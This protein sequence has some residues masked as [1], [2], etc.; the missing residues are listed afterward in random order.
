MKLTLLTLL[1]T[2]AFAQCTG[3]PP[4]WPS[5]A[6]GVTCMWNGYSE[7]Q[8]P[9]TP[10]CQNMRMGTNITEYDASYYDPSE[11]QYD[12]CVSTLYVCDSN[13][14]VFL[15]AAEKHRATK[16]WMPDFTKLFSFMLPKFPHYGWAAIGRYGKCQ[17]VSKI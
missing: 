16:Q 10:Y 4:C 8:S 11:G 15:S 7:C 2:A 17:L 3:I 13:C 6:E 12:S 1:A 14:P 9:N 5:Y